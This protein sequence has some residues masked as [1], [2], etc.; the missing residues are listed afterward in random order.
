MT[1]ERA[2]WPGQLAA[3]DMGSNSFR[4][5]IGQ[6]VAGRYRRVDYL[7]E[8]VRLGAGLDADGM[9]GDAAAARG[10][11][12]LA[13]FSRRLEGFGAGQVRAVATQTLR[14]AKNRNAFLARAQD[15]LGLPIEIISGREEARLIYGGVA[16]LQ[17]SDERRLVVDIGGRSTEMI[18]GRGPRPQRAESFQVGC[19][20]LSMTYFPDGRFSE[21]GFREAQIAAGA[22]LEEA[23]E[24]FAPQHW[25]EA[26]GASGTVGAVSQVLAASGVGDG[27]IT[28]AGLRWLIDRCIEAGSA[29]R[30]ALPGLK[31]DRRAVLGGGLAILYTLAA[32]FG[33]DRLRAAR[34]ALRQG[35]IFEMA[36]REALDL[37]RPTSGE[38]AREA[39]VRELQRRFL[40]DAAQAE[41]VGE[42]ALALLAGAHPKAGNEAR[43]ELRWAAAL[44][45][46]GMMISHHDFHRHGAYVLAHVDAPGFSQSQLRRIGDLVLGQRGGLRKL[47]TQL[48]DDRLFALHLL[49]LRLAAIVCHAREDVPSGAIALV[50]DAAQPLIVVTT[51]W[52]DQHPRALHLLRLELEAWT[53]TA[54][55]EPALQLGAA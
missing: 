19:V 12:C 42:L 39:S 24:P 30:L 54:S 33:I 34:G 13:A 26:L 5:E 22:E 28:P 46:A 14:E 36:A 8:A 50:A 25:N 29:D 10:L 6:F 55:L 27:S 15:A 3:I 11:A 31:D 48:Q 35:V 23:L 43:R 40:V 51:A 20:S 16:H 1:R 41:R 47:A 44:H 17:P 53:K 37:R 7:K 45:E 21:Q 52:A 32:H 2:R 4:L 18:L 38:D 9:L 49:C